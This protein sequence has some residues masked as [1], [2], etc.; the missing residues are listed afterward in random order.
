M[1]FKSFLKKFVLYPAIALAGYGGY[2]AALDV[3][4]VK[5]I[6][7]VEGEAPTKEE[8]KID[9]EAHYAELLYKR[10]GQ[11]SD[12]QLADLKN[13]ST[14]KG[15]MSQFDSLGLDTASI[16]RKAF[17]V[18]SI[19]DAQIDYLNDFMVYGEGDYWATPLQTI[20]EK[21]GDSEDIS[22]LKECALDYLDVPLKDIF[23]S[24]VSSKEDLKPES[25]ELAVD[26]AGSGNVEN[27]VL[28]EGDG[29]GRIAPLTE[30]TYTYHIGINGNGI[31]YI[32]PA[33]K[34]SVP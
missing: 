23:A 15:W 28:L 4:G 9:Q 11:R 19:V 18:D 21:R 29:L 2:H 20:K 3:Y 17:V 30:K 22:R 5:G 33:A 27:L 7:I 8:T 6:D 12:F 14:Y 25:V 24:V 16:A 31:R 10:T 34:D 1:S 13:D 32:T 26:T